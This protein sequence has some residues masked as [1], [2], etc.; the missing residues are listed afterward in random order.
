MGLRR[1]Q[2]D[3]GT[4]DAVANYTPFRLQQVQ[5]EW[6]QVLN[7]EA[8]YNPLIGGEI[9]DI[10]GLNVPFKINERSFI[11]LQVFLDLS[12]RPMHSE[13]CHTGNHLPWLANGE[14]WLGWPK[15]FSVSDPQE[16]IP[17]YGIQNH[18]ENNSRGV[19]HHTASPIPSHKSKTWKQ[20]D[21]GW[22]N[23]NIGMDTATGASG[24][25]GGNGN[26]DP[27]ISFNV[28]TGTWR[29]NNYYTGIDRELRKCICTQKE[30][31]TY[32]NK[33]FG[34]NPP[35]NIRRQRKGYSLTQ[36]NQPI[37]RGF[38]EEGGSRYPVAHGRAGVIHQ[39]R[40]F[41]NLY[42][43]IL[44]DWLEET[45]K[46]FKTVMDQVACYYPIAYATGQSRPI[47]EHVA[48]IEIPPDKSQ[49]RPAYQVMQACKTHLQLMT[50]LE[51][52]LKLKILMPYQ[53]MDS[54]VPSKSEG[55]GVTNAL[56]WGQKY[57]YYPK[58]DGN[59]YYS[60]EFPYP[61]WYCKHFFDARPT[62]A[63]DL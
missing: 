56:D 7:G 21:G 6:F 60:R 57:K 62:D 47:A 29:K 55:R 52:D 15:M 53:G 1:A 35:F 46:T 48:G 38:Y 5:D 36:A 25:G 27:E 39:S 31:G 18:S 2:L 33:S 24:G 40:E 28:H 23:V 41:N 54:R 30:V 58:A 4:A 45:G 3:A 59:H 12:G 17:Y 14:K 19:M 61:Y 9:L 13:I 16:S 51:G 20:R 42:K 43:A 34:H 8:F 32:A 22:W 26:A 49:N 63:I 10:H 44:K 37:S 50:L 11:Y